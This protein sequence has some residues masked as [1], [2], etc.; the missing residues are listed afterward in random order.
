MDTADIKSGTRVRY[1]PQA[2][3]LAAKGVDLSDARGTV[4]GAV[5]PMDREA[6]VELDE[7]DRL[8]RQSWKGVPGPER[9]R[10]QSEHREVPR[11]QLVA[12]LRDDAA[13]GRRYQFA[14]PGDLLPEVTHG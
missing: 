11:D 13:P 14:S 5:V 1:I 4:T 8:I 3:E 10:R 7:I 2:D 9:G 6:L 12:V